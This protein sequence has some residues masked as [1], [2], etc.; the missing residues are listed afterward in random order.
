MSL[1]LVRDGAG[2]D[3]PD[4]N[5]ATAR[6]LRRFLDCQ[7]HWFTIREL[8]EHL[9]IGSETARQHV[10]RLIA[11]GLLFTGQPLD[12][13]PL[14]ALCCGPHAGCSCATADCPCPLQR[15]LVLAR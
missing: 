13:M 8:S 6:T 15:L 2:A 1:R 3:L 12:A 11:S 14:S 10:R 5:D 7:G 4:W 9:D